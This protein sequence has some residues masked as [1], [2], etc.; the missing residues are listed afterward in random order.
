[1]VKNWLKSKLSY[2]ALGFIILHPILDVLSYFLS[3]YGDNTISTLARFAF[4]LA[5]SLVGFMV[6][7]QKRHYYI[8]Y[9][10][11]GIFWL[12]HCL[13][14][15]R[16]GYQSVVADTSNYL[17]IVSLPIYTLSLVTFF[18]EGKRIRKSI[19]IGFAVN[20]A[21]IILFTAIPWLS[22]HPVYTY[23]APLE[24]GV[25][26]WF[27]VRSA[28]SAIIALITPISILFAY[29]TKNDLF[30]LLTVTLTM[31]LLFMTGTKLTY[32]SILLICAALIFLFWIN[33][34]N[35]SASLRYILPLALILVLS[36]VFK[37][38]SPTSQRDM[39]TATA[40]GNYQGLVEASVKGSDTNS[41]G[42]S[43]AR[44]S[45]KPR[46]LERYE[47]VER[48]RKV[49]FGVYTDKKVYG[50]IYKDI[51]DRFGVYNVMD[52]FDNTT[53]TS[54]LSDSRE[55]KLYF[56]KL[57]WTEKDTLT[58]LLG[59][60][61]S[62][63]IHRATNYDLENDFPAVYYFCGYIGF[64]FYMLYFVY[65]F[66]IV[67]RAFT[68][69]LLGF[70]TVEV[71]I[72]GISFILAL[73]AAQ[74]SG[75]VLRRPNVTGYFA[76]I[77]AYLFDLCVLNPPE[78]VPLSVLLENPNFIKF[79]KLPLVQKLRNWFQPLVSFCAKA[80]LRWQT[81]LRKKKHA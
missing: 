44:G 18:K 72:V 19:C 36:V 6:S 7:D 64:F 34:K 79:T 22:G 9:G 73:G 65:F 16:I 51:N 62:D 42:S 74:I 60:E 15:Y 55:R 49:L 31:L 28:Q 70:L 43:G 39:R 20:L 45:S 61:Y 81:A 8:I 21:L 38:Y 71:G 13:N 1:M 76:L 69:N 68:R 3:E 77:A 53:E 37:S 10:V 59:F 47:E 75:N 23:E 48:G 66:F 58:H 52:I 67:I 2:I 30:Y 24:I 12:L 63:M 25:M 11:I 33:H 50:T 26:G 4:L 17:R 54:I 57:V 41:I 78:K 56:A 27:G 32:Y 46:P 29:R 5:I 40:Q 80:S 35:K 14:C